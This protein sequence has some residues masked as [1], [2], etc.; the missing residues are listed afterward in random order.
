[1]TDRLAY[2]VAEAAEALSIS[3]ALLKEE[4]YQGRIQHVKMG[5]R[6]LIPRWALEQRLGMPICI[7]CMAREAVTSNGAADYHTQEDL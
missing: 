7:T 3:Q 2:S 1:M 6:T 4:I 5:R